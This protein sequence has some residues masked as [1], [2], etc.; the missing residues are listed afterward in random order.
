MSKNVGDLSVL[1]SMR[2]D[3]RE[4][5]L[6][7]KDITHSQKM[8]KGMTEAGNSRHPVMHPMTA[9]MGDANKSIIAQ[10]DADQEKLRYQ[11]WLK[12]NAASASQQELQAIA[13]EKSARAELMAQDAARIAARKASEAESTAYQNW[14]KQNA[15]G[16]TQQ[17]LQAIAMKKAARDAAMAEEKRQAS[18]RMAMERQ[19]AL[20]A[21]ANA[22]NAGF[23]ANG[24]SAAFQQSLVDQD[25]RR[26]WAE[27]GRIRDQALRDEVQAVRLAAI[28][29]R[30]AEIAAQKAVTTAHII[31]TV[32]RQQADASAQRMLVFDANRPLVIPDGTRGK[33]GGGNLGSTSADN[34]M[35][36]RGFV[37]AMAI[38]QMGFAVQDFSSQM[39]NA[40][41]TADGLGRG[42]MAVSNNVQMLGAAFGPTGLAVTAIGGAIAG[43]VLP[44]MIRWVYQAEILK[45]E[46][47]EAKDQAREYAEELR[48]AQETKD[49]KTTSLPGM[50]TKE[51]EAMRT[52][53][54]NS[55]RTEIEQTQAE[56][57]S[58]N[59]IIEREKRK[60]DA[61]LRRSAYGSL[62]AGAFT[63]NTGA[64][65]EAEA[66]RDELRQQLDDQK[67]HYAAV[68]NVSRET[69]DKLAENDYE[70]DRK[71]RDMERKAAEDRLAQYDR[72]REHEREFNDWAIDE[73]I[74]TENKKQA[75]ISENLDNLKKLDQTP[76]GSSAANIRGTGAAVSAIN[77]AIAGTNSEE[78]DRKKQIRIA[79]EQL[80]SSQNIEKKLNLQRAAL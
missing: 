3:N 42:I 11:T 15:S 2:Y 70:V 6:F 22:L 78:S 69:K 60:R 28:E 35:N 49:T 46:M 65:T 55:L 31:E 58:Q 12:E 41:T 7:I 10:Q 38:Q 59:A 57:Q 52:Q 5:D 19:Q 54:K 40:K 43:V 74:K 8:L 61:N 77:R 71:R 37:G 67:A 33:F 56:L 80:K 39:V 13:A 51:F 1:L 79:E 32:R 30:N 20:A 72:D 21:K 76:N 73:K 36:N 27:R 18:E 34:N 50:T 64:Q 29:K 63:G 26:E 53:R 16:Q 68:D 44:P 17:E 45:E 62:I 9:A 47:A 48:R 23:S 75:A 4:A 24:V 25:N 66:K 14:L